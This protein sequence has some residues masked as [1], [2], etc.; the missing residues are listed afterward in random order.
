MISKHDDHPSS[1][2]RRMMTQQDLQGIDGAELI[3]QFNANW[4][5]YASIHLHRTKFP[6]LSTLLSHI[7]LAISKAVLSAIFHAPNQ[8]SSLPLSPSPSLS[9]SF[10]PSPLLSLLFSP[11][12]DSAP[13]TGLGRWGRRRPCYPSAWTMSKTGPL[14][15]LFS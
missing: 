12:P 2:P 10:S 14:S 7:A 13:A 1:R 9:L 5:R 11:S 3:K 8:L 4:R 6:F 15:R